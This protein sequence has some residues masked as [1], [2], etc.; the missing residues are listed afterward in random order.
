MNR[1]TTMLD[2]V[3]EIARQVR[4]DAEI[5]ER[6]TSLVNSGRV[7]LTGSFRGTT[8]FGARR[9]LEHARSRRRVR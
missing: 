1:N 8:S 7:P 4:S 9:G 6:V 5:V 3:C 2:L